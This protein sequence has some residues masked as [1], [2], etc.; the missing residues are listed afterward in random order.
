[1]GGGHSHVGS[2]H[3]ARDTPVH[4]TAATVK[5]VALVGFLLASMPRW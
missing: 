5:L 2:L 3:D 1:M 4:A